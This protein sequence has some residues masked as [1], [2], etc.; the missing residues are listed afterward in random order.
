MQIAGT[1]VMLGTIEGALR[2]E[3]YMRRVVY[4]ELVLKGI[5]GRLMYSTWELLKDILQSG[6]MD[7]SH[8]VG[9]E[10]TLADYQQGLERFSDVLGRIVLYP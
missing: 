7:A 3:N 5:F 2:I 10:Y 9:A 6:R 1:C 8:Y 4:R